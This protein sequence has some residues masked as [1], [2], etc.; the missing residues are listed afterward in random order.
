MKFIVDAQL[1]KTLSEFLKYKGFDAIHTLDLPA[2]N[3]THDKEIVDFATLENRI[4]ITKDIDF[5]ASFLIISQPQKLILVRTGNITNT[6]LIN[7]FSKNLNLII[8]LLEQSN[9]VEIS[10]TQIVEHK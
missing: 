4:V 2:K 5:L 7:L 8:D 10:S 6:L 3:E 9:L 1:P